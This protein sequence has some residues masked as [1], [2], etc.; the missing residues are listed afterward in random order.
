MYK[1]PVVSFIPADKWWERAKWQLEEDYQGY[2][3]Q[4]VPKGF[5]TDGASVPFLFQWLF[6]P[7]GQYFGASIIHDYLL[8]SSGNWNIANELFEIE[9]KASNTPKW[10]VTVMM[11]GVNFWAF[12]RSV[13]L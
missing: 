11:L 12:R 8:V 4:K 9:L 3:G 13:R 5:I 7:T 2:S 1:Q 10:R 6:S